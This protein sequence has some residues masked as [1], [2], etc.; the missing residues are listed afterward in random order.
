MDNKAIDRP[1]DE[2]ILKQATSMA[3]DYHIVLEGD[4][5]S[6][7]VGTWCEY[8]SIIG[9]GETKEECI[10]STREAIT[11]ALAY[12]LETGQELPKVNEEL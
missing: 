12:L 1:F 11:V 3:Q 6:G 8:P 2:E 4:Q 7:F 10:E 9:D 5:K